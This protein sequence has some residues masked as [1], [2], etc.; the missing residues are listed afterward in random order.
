MA[1]DPVHSTDVSRTVDPLEAKVVVF[2][3]QPEAKGFAALRQELRDAGRGELL[4]DV[5]ATW[6]QHERDPGRAA[7]HRRAAVL[8]NDHLGRVD[9]ALWHWQQAWKLEPQRTE[10]LEAARELYRSLGDDAMVAK[11][12]Q[13][14]LEVLGKD[15]RAAKQA[16]IRLELGRL[17]LRGKDLEAAANHNE[18]ASRLDHGSVA[19]AAAL[20]VVY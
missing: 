5:C 18:A 19:L 13:A 8:W 15:G 17:A 11:L 2:R 1:D 9:R 12:Y 14:E 10:A 3:Q 16:R 7:Q 4:A 6:A 20:A